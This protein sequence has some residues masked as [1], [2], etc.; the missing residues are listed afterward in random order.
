LEWRRVRK[1]TLLGFAKVQFSS[2]LIIAE[3]AVHAHGKR[4]WVQPPSRP[5]IENGEVVR[6]DRGR[7]RYQPLIS[8][9]NH[10]VQ[11]SF[12]RQVIRAVQ[13]GA[14]DELPHDNDLLI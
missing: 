11:S 13:E 2:G 9:A 5:W 6:E 1:N 14:P 8:F 7:I 4:L 10:G 12:S 3:I